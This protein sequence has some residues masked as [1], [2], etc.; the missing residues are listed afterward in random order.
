MSE[1][2]TAERWPGYGEQSWSQRFTELDRRYSE[3]LGNIESIVRAVQANTVLSTRT[4]PQPSGGEVDDRCDRYEEAL[5][6][7]V[8]WAD[9]YPLKV[10]PEPDFAVCAQALKNAGQTLDAVSASNMRHVVEGV[11]KIAR[12]ALD[13]TGGADERRS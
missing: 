9:A 8:Q 4:P 7:I 2:E 10:F 3:A 13:R 12:S 1:V 6:Q 5:Q 11:G